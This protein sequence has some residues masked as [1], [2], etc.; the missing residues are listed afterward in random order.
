MDCRRMDEL[1]GS[2]THKESFPPQTS[3][4]PRRHICSAPSL[5][6]ASSP[7][8]WNGERSGKGGGGNKNGR[9]EVFCQRRIGTVDLV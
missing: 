3:T 7:S 9:T 5:D 6:E 1:T 2:R 4:P 8:K